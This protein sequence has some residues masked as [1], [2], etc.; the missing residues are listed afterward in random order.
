MDIAITPTI[1]YKQ[2]AQGILQVW[3]IWYEDD[4]IY[5]EWGQEG[6][7]MQEQTEEILESKAARSV[8]E[9]VLSRINS[10][11]EKKLD[12]G[13]VYNKAEA[14]ANKPTNRLGL[15]KPMLATPFDRVKGIDFETSWL[16]AK[17]DGH[18]CLVHR[19]DKDNYIA[20]S[21]NGKVIHSIPEI[22][23]AIDD[24]DMSVGATL[25]G[26]LY[27]HGTPLQRITSWVKR[28]QANTLNLHYV[29]YDIMITG[30]GYKL[31]HA[32]LESFFKGKSEQF[33]R[34]APTMPCPAASE[35]AYHLRSTIEDGYEGLIL[36]RSGFPYEDGKRSKGLVKIK[37]FQDDEFLVVDINPSREGYAILTCAT[38]DGKKFNATAPGDMT[39]KMR[40]MNHKQDFI[41]RFVQLKY[42]NLT[43]DGVPFH[44]IATMWRNKLGE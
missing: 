36:R 26:E 11:I 32:L 20:Y 27:H 31:R 23:R 12:Q 10:R 28:R 6:G 33:V 24:L 1:L 42:A 38:K 15:M 9:Q 43:E 16:Q 8:E 3:S 21:R 30:G 17:Y 29:V 18:R 34:L 35:I 7:E 4:T 41:G 37:Q 14:Q 40:V 13:Y 5:I 25:D 39:Q 44:P 22:L 19:R 2:S